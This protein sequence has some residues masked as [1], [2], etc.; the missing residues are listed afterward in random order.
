MDAD[1]GIYLV[2]RSWFGVSTAR[3]ASCADYCNSSGEVE[4]L[5]EACYGATTASG[6]VAVAMLMPGPWRNVSLH[7]HA[8]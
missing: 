7:G 8:R 1:E 2:V 4:I 3:I 6:G 5:K